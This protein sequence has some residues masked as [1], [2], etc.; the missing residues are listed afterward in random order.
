[1]KLVIFLLFFFFPP[2]TKPDFRWARGPGQPKNATVERVVSP[3]H[4]IRAFLILP[5]IFF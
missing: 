5:M 1:M 3:L 4:N 2:Y